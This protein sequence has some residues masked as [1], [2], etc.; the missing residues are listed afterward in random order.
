MPVRLRQS[1]IDNPMLDAKG[2][3]AV[4]FAPVGLSGG[5]REQLKYRRRSRMELDS[6]D[7]LKGFESPP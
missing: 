3:C 4:R 6:A 1:C 7:A 5:E 2:T